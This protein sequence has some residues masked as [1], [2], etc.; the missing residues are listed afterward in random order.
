MSELEE[1]ARQP[2][3]SPG[4]KLWMAPRIA[5]LIP[6]HRIYVE[7][8][9]GAAAVF[10]AKEPSEVEVLGDI[11]P[12]VMFAYRFI[13]RASSKEIARL[14]RYEWRHRRDLFEE[15]KAARPKDE[16]ERFRRF[17]YLRKA[18]YGSRGVNFMEAKRERAISLDSFE[19]WQE[20]L[21]GVHLHTGSYEQLL[22]RYD[23]QDAFFYLDPPY[24][25]H[26][27]G[28][29]HG[30]TQ[31]QWD[32]LIERLKRLK[33]KFIL[34]LF[35]DLAGT[36]P[37]G[38]HTR[39]IK[40]HRALGQDDA[41][42]VLFHYE[43]LAAN[44]PLG[45]KL[46]AEDGQV[47]DL[48]WGANQPFGSPAGKTYLARRIAAMLPPHKTYVE[49]FA[50]GAAVFWAKEPVEREVLNDIDPEIAFAY[51]FL[52]KMT[53][54]QFARLKRFDWER[55]PDKFEKVKRSKPRDEVERFHKFYYLTLASFGHARNT[56]GWGKGGNVIDIDKL[57]RYTQRLKNVAIHNEDF[58]PVVRRYDSQET[59]FYLDP[60]YPG[61]VFHGPQFTLEDLERLIKVLKGIKGRFVLSLGTEH[62]RYLPESWFVKRVKVQRNL[63]DPRTGKPIPSGFEILAANFTPGR[64]SLEA[65]ETDEEG[66]AAPDEAMI[67][68]PE[69]TDFMVI[70]DFISLVGSAV[71]GEAPKDLD[72]LIRSAARSESLEVAIGKQ[73]DP[74]KRGY[75]HFIYEPA[76]PHDDYIPL[77]DLVALRKPG[78]E[79]VEVGLSRAKGL[80]P[81]KP[82]TPLKTAG[83]Y[84]E[85]EFSVDAADKLWETWGQG[86]KDVGLI[87]QEK[88]DGYRLTLHRK[89]DRVFAFSEDARRD[90][91]SALP[92][93]EEDLKALPDGDFILDSELL[94]YAEEAVELN[95]PYKPGDK[96]ER[97]DMASFLGKSPA[98]RFRALCQVFDCL[99]L[100]G[101]DLHQ[102][103]QTERLEALHKLLSPVDTLHLKEVESRLV[104]S[105]EEFLKAVKW[106]AS[107]P[108]SEGAMV[109]VADSDYPLTGRSSTIAKLKNFK[110][111]RGRVVSKRKTEAGAYVYEIALSDGSVIGSTYATRLEA[112]VG[113]ILEVRAAEIKVKEEDGRR[114]FTWDNPIVVSIKPKGTA[115]TTPEQAEA[116]AR[117]RRGMTAEEE[118]ETRSEA[119]ERFWRENWHKSFP[120]SGKGEFVY[121]HHWRGLSEEETKLS[122]DELLK[123]DHS[124]HGDLR[125]QFSDEALFGF[126][127]FLGTTDEMGEA[128]G[129]RLAN[130]PPD[131][132]L[133][134]AWKLQQPIAWLKVGREKPLVTAPGEVGATSEKYS[135]FFAEDWGTYEIGVWREHF[136]EL[137]LHGRKLKGRYTI[138][139]APLGGRRVWLIGKPKDQTPY[140]EAHE[141]EDVVKE[142]KGKGQRYLV[143]ARPGEEPKLIEV[144]KAEQLTCPKCGE[145]LDPGTTRLAKLSDDFHDVFRCAH[146]RHIFSP[147]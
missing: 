73:L 15:L 58:E 92:G 41:G 87:V 63:V 26:W 49:P 16:V 98:A 93:L 127:V 56:F 10:W 55:R 47:E 101:E 112:E 137:F 71:K 138:Q 84:G 12:E 86:Y 142:L 122:E 34:S 78:I 67:E 146:C 69:I 94:L 130:L 60:P 7:P 97:M 44:F 141:L 28:E 27:Q 13:Q 2:F 24:P 62:E 35:K 43:Y 99:Y 103:P 143:W 104:R 119:A 88:F 102:R 25:G 48:R 76:G 57:E 8:F 96:I 64:E 50:G 106:A 46:E 89:G 90:I 3:G 129:D 135:K 72:I 53:P 145:T 6:P 70:P 52:K 31:E 117:K 39:R 131:D 54:E 108:H 120:P 136:F 83:G 91:V 115:L 121:H 110:E 81:G 111:I 61:R 74:E 118:G 66:E 147:S 1:L 20:R 124:V 18:S 51:R 40:T 38:W 33:G 4:G 134:G 107:R 144:G 11:D 79:V 22:D 37:S 30:F 132:K 45:G 139:Y 123:T 133:Q 36:L 19:R 80:V 109:K 114:V 17:L 140:A 68:L 23:G 29:E 125:L 105:R 65:L 9:A 59:V 116:M 82:F 21:K 126:T 113:D 95:N 77:W 5:S 128:G 100:N 75:L 32:G 14:R 85:L 42:K